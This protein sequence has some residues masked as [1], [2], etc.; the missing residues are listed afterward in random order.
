MKKIV[1]FF[2]KNELG[3]ALYLFLIGI[4]NTFGLGSIIQSNVAVGKK[5]L[6][7]QNKYNAVQKFFGFIPFISI[8]LLSLG[9]IFGVVDKESLNIFKDN[10][11]P[12]IEKAPDSLKVDSSKIKNLEIFQVDSLKKDS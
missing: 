8:V 4:L 6:D 7:G 3:K 1:E 12:V 2:T 9:A 11:E 10:L 5:S